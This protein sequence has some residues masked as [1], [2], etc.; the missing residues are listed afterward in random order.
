[1][2]HLRAS[3]LL[4]LLVGLVIL[5]AWASPGIAL[6]E[7]D[8]LFLVGEKAFDDGLYP[9]SR[10]MLE[11]FVERF[12]SDRR[13]GEAT[14]LLGKARLS[15]GAG[16]AALEAFK[17]AESFQPP[18]GKPGELRF[19]EAEAFYRLKRFS[20][21]RTAY[22][23]VIAAGA[24]GSRV[25]DALY[26]L[27]W[28]ELEA[29]RREPAAAAFQR[30]VSEFPDHA[31]APTAT[32]QL[33]RTL[34][35]L[36]RADDAQGVLQAFVTKNPEHKLAPEARYWQARARLAAGQTDQGVTDLRA[37]AKA[38]PTSELAPAARRAVLDTLMKDGRKSELGDEY[39]A[40]MSQKP[41]SA[42]GLYDAGAI[43]ERLGRSRDAEAARARLRT[44]FPEHP[45]TGRAS[46][47]SA[48]AA[49]TKNAFRDAATL[50]RAATKSPEEPVRGEAFLL[51][52][53]SE[54]KL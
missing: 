46:L 48:Q 9:L 10:R 5:G 3:L 31:L 50:A 47:Q 27:G 54:M 12:S 20:D 25:P 1:M 7:A 28:S 35:E 21:A 51:V 42:D 24:A 22:S 44:E 2:A 53:E 15:Q 45:L 49:F 41:A 39:T 29:K 32:I 4:S 43:A 40:L 8:R 6:E 52:G 13:A 38:N 16:E 17:K 33:A 36:K 18:P 37:F 23:D 11:R 26:G 34:I 19:W 30:L 14:L